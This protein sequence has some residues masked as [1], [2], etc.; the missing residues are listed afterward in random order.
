MSGSEVR[1]RSG[2]L[3]LGEN[4]FGE[5]HGAGERALGVDEVDGADGF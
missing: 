4:E 1:E 2:V 3:G 5:G